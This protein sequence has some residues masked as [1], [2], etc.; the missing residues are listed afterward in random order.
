MKALR[1]NKIIAQRQQTRRKS[2]T[3]VSQNRKVEK[4]L[5]DMEALSANK[6]IENVKNVYDKQDKYRERDYLNGS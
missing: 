5:C 6:N 2:R 4:N 3:P 1:A